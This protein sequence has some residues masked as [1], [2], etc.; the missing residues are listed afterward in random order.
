MLFKKGHIP[1]NKGKSIDNHWNGRKHSIKS[2]EKMSETRTKLFDEGK[3]EL[4]STI[5]HKGNI[6]WIKGKHHSK[7]TKDKISETK[8]DVKQTIEHRENTSK[9]LKGN[10]NA[11]GQIPWNYIDGRSKF[12]PPLRYGD[13]WDAIRLVVYRRDKFTCQDC[14]II[15]KSLDIHHKIPYLFSGDNSIENLIALCRKC[16]MKAEHK[17]KEQYRNIETIIR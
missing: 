10:T 6:P 12:L 3:L 15:G 9:S 7:K 17:I 2:K 16:H 4:S 1:W 11:K 14:G 5:F 8:T 13:D